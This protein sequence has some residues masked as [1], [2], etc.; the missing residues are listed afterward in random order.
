MVVQVLLLSSNLTQGSWMRIMSV[1]WCVRYTPVRGKTTPKNPES[2]PHETF[3][4]LNQQQKQLQLGQEFLSRQ[5]G[6]GEIEFQSFSQFR[7][8]VV[9][10]QPTR[11][12]I[13][14]IF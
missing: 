7:G 8:V 9:E 14:A 2:P 11:N 4:H 5:I 6:A 1:V 13:F 12:K 10:I 3:I